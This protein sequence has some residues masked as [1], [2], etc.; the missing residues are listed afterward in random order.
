MPFHFAFDSVHEL[1]YC[2]FSGAMDDKSLM[3]Y[4]AAAEIH[5]RNTKPKMAL[6]EFKDITNVEVSITALAF[7]AGSA[8]TLPEFAK[9]RVL[10]APTD[11][12]YGKCRAF[13]MMG[14]AT[15]PSLC[16]VRTLEEAYSLLGVSNPQFVPLP[17]TPLSQQ[18]I[19]HRSIAAGD[20]SR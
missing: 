10:V 4:Y 19:H 5:V 13:E 16:I 9:P 12:V 2:E 14:E 7:L 11:V 18:D 20:E 6:L 17:G 1:F 3:E 15:R 8:P